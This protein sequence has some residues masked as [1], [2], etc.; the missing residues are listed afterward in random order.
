MIIVAGDAAAAAGGGAATL[1]A[2]YCYGEGL[3]KKSGKMKEK[4]K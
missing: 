4:K 3:K 2:W 1:D